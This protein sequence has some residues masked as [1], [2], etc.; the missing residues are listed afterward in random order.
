MGEATHL[1]AEIRAARG[2][3]LKEVA[4]LSEDVLCSIPPGETWSAAELLAHLVD[5]DYFYL[6]EALA[7]CAQPGRPFRY[8]DDDLWRTLRADGAPE[9]APSI[10]ARL[11]RSHNLVLASLRMLTAR[12]LETPALHPRGIDYSVRDIF[13]RFAV[14]DRNHTH[15]LSA[16]LDSHVPPI[17]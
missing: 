8:F 2:R 7:T 13:A 9:S 15:Q 6:S 17:S 14:H 10:R 1:I 11:D 4:G 16:M 5:V 3:L 12:E